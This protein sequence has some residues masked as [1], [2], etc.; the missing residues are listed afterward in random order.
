MIGKSWYALHVLIKVDLSDCSRILVNEDVYGLEMTD[1]E[2]EWDI[3]Q[4]LVKEIQASLDTTSLKRT[5]LGIRK[6]IKI[7]PEVRISPALN[8][9]SIHGKLLTSIQYELADEACLKTIAAE[10]DYHVSARLL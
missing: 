2:S 10:D 1:G 7:E 3:A 6:I 5:C 9:A 8:L 4:C